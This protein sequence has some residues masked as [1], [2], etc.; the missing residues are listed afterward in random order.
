MTKAVVRSVT[1]AEVAHFTEHGWVHLPAL[2]DAAVVEGLRFV[3]L[4]RLETNRRAAKGGVGYV[5]RAF[6]QDRDIAA[7]EPDFR[8]IAHHRNMG[9]NAIRLLGSV[10]RVRLQIS[11][12]LVKEPVGSTRNSEETAYHQDFPWLPMD[13]SSMLTVWVALV[14]VAAEMG[15]LRFYDRSHRLGL[16]GRSFVRD[17][18]DMLSQ[19]PWLHGYSVAGGGDLQAGDATVHHAL[20]VHGAPANTTDRRRLSFTATYFGAD[21]LYTGA[22][23]AQT[24]DLEPALAIGSPFES[25]RFPLIET[26]MTE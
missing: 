17:G 7:I 4:E 23:H 12:L 24:D 13:R 26:G 21:A 14:P 22:P 11:N 8:M 6:G 5:D 9:D 10:Q 15:S 3:A 18:D 25:P 2:I 1:S 20:T 16:L 19:H